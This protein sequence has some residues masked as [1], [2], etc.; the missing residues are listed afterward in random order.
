MCNYDAENLHCVRLQKMAQVN[1]PVEIVEE[2][3]KVESELDPSLHLTLV[4]FVGVHYARWVVQ[5]CAI[6]RKNV[7]PI[8]L[9]HKLCGK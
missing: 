5:A 2:G 3:E 9:Q 4:K 7:K 1:L 6:K 8:K